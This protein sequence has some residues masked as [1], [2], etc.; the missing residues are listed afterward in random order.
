VDISE[1]ALRA[2]VAWF[3][4]LAGGGFPQISARDGFAVSTGLDSNTDNGAVIAPSVLD[5]PLELD[6]LLVWLRERAVPASMLVT[7]PLEAEATAR[8]I[9]RGLEAECT[10]NNMGRLLGGF[11]PT[12]RGYPRRGGRSVK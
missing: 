4:G 9:D 8:L 3:R 11:A 1:L 12:P 7:G 10:G 5:N 2:Q 6:A